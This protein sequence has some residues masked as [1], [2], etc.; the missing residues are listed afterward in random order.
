MKENEP[1][2]ETGAGYADADSPPDVERE[3]IW[4]IN[5]KD[6]RLFQALTL[7]GGNAGSIAVTVLQLKH[8]SPDD[9][10][11]TIA[12]N[13]ILGIGASFVASGFISWDLVQIKEVS[14]AVADWIRDRNARNRAKLVAQGLERGLEQG[15]ERGLEQGLERGLEQGLERGLEQGRVEG[16]AE[17]RVEGYYIG[18]SDAQEGN[19]Q[20]PPSGNDDQSS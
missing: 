3:T 5:R 19:P 10:P 8:R 9:T 11:D 4:G 16:R 2:D 6:R 15:L 14:M 20:R 18:Y 1:R 13:I 12:L 17:G 7:T